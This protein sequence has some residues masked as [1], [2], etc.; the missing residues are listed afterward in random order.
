MLQG[1][2]WAEL[3]SMYEVFKFLNRFC[4]FIYAQTLSAGHVTNA[5]VM[6]WEDELDQVQPLI[7][8][9]SGTFLFPL[10][11]LHHHS[12][13]HSAPP[14][15]ASNGAEIPSSTGLLTSFSTF[16]LA[17]TYFKD[18]INVLLLAARLQIQQY[19]FFA[20]PDEP[21]LGLRTNTLRVFQ[22]SRV[23]ISTVYE[24]E[25]RHRFLGH[26]PYWVFRAVLDACSIILFVL[27]SNYA[28]DISPDD[29]NLVA[30]QSCNCVLG[31][32]TRRNDMPYRAG[33]VM[34]TFW[35]A[36]HLI[37]KVDRPPAAWPTR[38]GSGVTFVCAR[39]FKND[40]AVARKS[41]ESINKR[42]EAIRTC[43]SPLSLFLSLKSFPYPPNAYQ[44]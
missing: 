31:F 35:M 5:V 9:R 6:Q 26:S 37:P 19:Y 29:A 3:L 40:L 10:H 13:P 15:F 11:L 30:Q 28:P 25:T 44:S 36:R 17:A 7:S 24:L 8:H 39:R 32:S 14:G 21:V 22:T 12:I 1:A 34:E 4:R 33:T 16:P 41:S 43:S 27:L 42:L 18:S 2:E 20:P 23:L 38:L